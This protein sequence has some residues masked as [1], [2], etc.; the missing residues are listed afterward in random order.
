[1]QAA[2]PKVEELDFRKRLPS[3]EDAQHLAALPGLQRIMISSI[4]RTE[5]PEELLQDIHDLGACLQ[6]IVLFVYCLN[7]L[8]ESI[9]E[10]LPRL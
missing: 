10:R 4:L 2:F 3:V 7:R 6:V 1:M 9:G 5:D 8:P